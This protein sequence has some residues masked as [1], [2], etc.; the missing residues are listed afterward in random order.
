MIQFKKRYVILL[1][2]FLNVSLTLIRQAITSSQPVFFCGTT[3]PVSEF[4]A[5]LAPLPPIIAFF[6]IPLGIPLLYFLYVWRH[7]FRK[8]GIGSLV[9]GF[10]WSFPF[11]NNTSIYLPVTWN[12]VLGLIGIWLIYSVLGVLA[13]SYFTRE[14]VISPLS[15]QVALAFLIVPTL[16]LF[17][18]HLVYWSSTYLPMM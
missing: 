10:L 2:G 18:I 11:L 9:I 12:G 1:I 8:A 17:F 4:L 13:F 14:R 7:D 6:T 5:L 16:L 3:N 15:K